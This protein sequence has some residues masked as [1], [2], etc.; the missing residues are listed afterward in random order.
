MT[1]DHMTTTATT[2]TTNASAC[3]LRTRKLRAGVLQHAAGMPRRRRR[4]G[5]RSTMAAAARGANIPYAKEP[6]QSPIVYL[7]PIDKLH[8][9]QMGDKFVIEFDP[10]LLLGIL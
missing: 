9:L 2:T 7:L 8:R 4:W 6:P 3:S 10:P 5:E 1:H